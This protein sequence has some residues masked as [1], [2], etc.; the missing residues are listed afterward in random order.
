MWVTGHHQAGEPAVA[1]MSLGGG[2]DTT[3]DNAVSNS[4]GSGITYSVAAGNDYGATA[5]N[6][7]PARIPAAITVGS[8]ASNDSRSNFSNIGSCLDIF[9]PGSGITSDWLTN[10]TA[11]N[12]I[13]GTSMATPHVTGAAALVLKQYPTYTPQQ[14]RDYLVNNATNG[15]ISNPGNLSPNKLL[16]VVNFAPV[17]NDYRL[18]P[19]PASGTVSQGGTT[20]TTIA[21]AVTLGVSRPI[22]LSA[23][24]LPAGASATFS[25]AALNTGASSTL[26]IHTVATTPVGNYTITVTGT[27]TSPAVTRSTTY[28]LTVI[29][30]AGCVA[31]NPTDVAILDY[32]TVESTVTIWGCPGSAGTGSTVAVNIVHTYISDLV[33]ALE[34]P[35]GSV[36][37]LHNN[38]GGDADNIIKTYTLNL[39]AE[40]ANGVWRLRV[41]DYAALDTGLINAWGLNLAG[42]AGRCQATNN[43]DVP[44]PDLTTVQ[45]TIVITPCKGNASSTSIVEVRIVH[46]YIGDLIVTLIAPDG[47]PYVLQNRTGGSTDNIDRTYAVDLSTENRNGTWILRVQDAEAGD[48]G[49][50]DSWTLAL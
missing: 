18:T 21:T 19:T 26:S 16:F 4:I 47:T 40:V 27:G 24:G 50:L 31:S 7:S 48:T 29:G 6:T 12:T 44:I 14:V 11:T 39:S 36:Y 38:T 25:P 37:V 1:N 43:T 20:A 22:T 33:V 5:C 46:T 28:Q 3:L 15:A 35:D 49:Y 41:T 34:A 45:S 17:A 10:D 9:A 23:S 2:I 30:P 13:S 42:T 32:T 8:T